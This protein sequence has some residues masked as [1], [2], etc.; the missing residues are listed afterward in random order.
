MTDLGED[1]SLSASQNETKS[2]D[3]STSSQ[4]VN[5]EVNDI[6]V[7]YTPESRNAQPY[8]ES[9]TSSGYPNWPRPA[10]ACNIPI[11]HG[12]NS[13]PAPTSEGK[14]KVRINEFTEVKEISE[15]GLDNTRDK[16]YEKIQLGPKNKLQKTRLVEKYKNREE[17]SDTSN[18]NT[19]KF[20]KGNFS[21]KSKLDDLLTIFN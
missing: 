21:S 3:N 16:R 19:L 18:S 17:N 2:K 12:S 7:P 4:R 10:P 14:K 9:S 5:L 15:S 13:E 20:F 6:P 1:L 11:Q 8:T